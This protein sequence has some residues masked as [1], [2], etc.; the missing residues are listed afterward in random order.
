MAPF[1]DKTLQSVY[2]NNI[3]FSFKIVSQT[4]FILEINVQKCSV[5]FIP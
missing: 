3:D 2:S 5:F 4:G 1:K